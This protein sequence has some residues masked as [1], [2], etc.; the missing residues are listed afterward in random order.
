MK[1]LFVAGQHIA[2]KIM[3]IDMIYFSVK[4][5]QYSTTVLARYTLLENLFTKDCGTVLAD[6]VLPLLAR[7]LMPY[8]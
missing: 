2:V 7:K 5:L 4:L 3:A 6:T 8:Q 1:Y